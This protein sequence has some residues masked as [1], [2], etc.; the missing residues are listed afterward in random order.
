LRAS[1]ARRSIASSKSEKRL[2]TPIWEECRAWAKENLARFTK[3]DAKYIDAVSPT[4]ALPSR[5]H[6]PR[7]PPQRSS[8]IASYLIGKKGLNTFVKCN[9]TLLGTSS[10]ERHGR[11]GYDYLVF[12]DFHFNDDLQYRDAVPMF[13]RLLELA[14]ENGVQFGLKRPTRSPSASRETNCPAARC[15]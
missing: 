11:H 4:S 5:S 14:C 7:L 1:R 12:D 9:P 6:A 15:T 3:V 10:R 13:K 2:R 8:A